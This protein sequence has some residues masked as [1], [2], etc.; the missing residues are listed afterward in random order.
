MCKHSSRTMCNCSV[1]HTP[2]QLR[3]VD[4]NEVFGTLS[5]GRQERRGNKMAENIENSDY[6]CTHCGK[7]IDHAMDY[8][9]GET[10]HICID[11]YS[12]LPGTLKKESMGIK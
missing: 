5:D 9:D 8:S 4:N 10:G 1:E 12:S 7:A 6:I 2:T 11:C 3:I